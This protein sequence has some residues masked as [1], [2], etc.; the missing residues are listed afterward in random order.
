MIHGL[1]ASA[2]FGPLRGAPPADVTALVD[3]LERLAAF[4]IA[5]GDQLASIDLNPIKV[6]PEGRGCRIVDALLIPALAHPQHCGTR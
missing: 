3:C 1:R 2:L 4:A 6:M 5:A